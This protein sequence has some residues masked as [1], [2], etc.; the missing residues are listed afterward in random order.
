[1]EGQFE[2]VAGLLAVAIL[3]PLGVHFGPLVFGNRSFAFRDAAHY[4]YPLYEWTC[5][6]WAAGRAPLWNPQENS[7]YPVLADATSSV[8]YPGKLLFTLPL[9]YSLR[10]KLY[11]VL[12]VLL[13]GIA[14][15][16]LSRHWHASRSAAAL[17]AISYAL[18][19]KVL[20]QN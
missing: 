10:Y 6:E 12:H 4:Y 7:G 17:A 3:L 14:A 13:A 8:F 5:H 19:G 16:G 1:M 15:Y 11:I 9:A 18:G 20:F 2:I